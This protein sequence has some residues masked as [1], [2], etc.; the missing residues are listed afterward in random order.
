MGF[1]TKC[2]AEEFTKSTSYVHNISNRLNDETRVTSSHV[3]GQCTTPLQSCSRDGGSPDG[4]HACWVLGLSQP[5]HAIEIQPPFA[6]ENQ[7]MSAPAND[8][9]TLAKLISDSVA[10][11]TSEYA[12]AGHAPPSLESTAQDPFHSPELVPEQLKAA[13]KII[14]AACAQLSAT[15]ASAGHVVTNKSYNFMEPV[16]MRVALD[17]RITDHLLDKP[18]GLHI[19]E[20]GQL[21][22]QDPGKLGRI[23]RTLAT[24]HVY[25]EVTPNVFANNRLSMKLLSTDPVSDLVRHMTDE[26]M[27]GGAVVGDV[28]KDP[29]TRKSYRLEDSPFQRAHGVSA[30]GYYGVPDRPEIFESFARAM[31]GWAQVTGKAML[32]KIY[33]WGSLPADSTI[34]D[35]GGGNGHAMLDLLKAFP[36][37][38]AIV[39]DTRAIAIQ[40]RE[41]WEKEY[42]IAIQEKKVDFIGLDFLTET[43]VTGGTVYYLRHVLHDWPDDDSIKILKNVRK[44]AGPKSRLLINEFVVQYIVRGGLASESQAPEPLLPN[45]GA[46][47]KRLYQQDLNMMF[48]F[49]SKERT[50]DEFIKLGEASGFRFEKLWDGGEAGIVELVPV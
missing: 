48:Q 25:T 12:K 38:K 5:S 11:V 21:T 3:R 49:N 28:F 15:V 8:L 24:N 33:P 32:P 40:G 17:A 30:F 14:E 22:D 27:K 26:S 43:P 44:S 39:Q 13:I 37:F 29:K 1:L 42:P 2:Q 45:Y 18:K 47:N 20:L 7:K 6:K 41:F 50:L 36:S 31:V 46:A 19:D 35:V 9:N 23:L 4:L 16:C 34:V 10:V